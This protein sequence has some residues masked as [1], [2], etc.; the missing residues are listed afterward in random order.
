MS[1]PNLLLA[2]GDRILRN[3]DSRDRFRKMPRFVEKKAVSA[4]DL[5]NVALGKIRNDLLRGCAAGR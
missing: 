4:A 1:N 2:I 5:E 3:I